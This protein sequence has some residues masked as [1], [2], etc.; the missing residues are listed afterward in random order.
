[1]GHMD[2]RMPV[3]RMIKVVTIAFI[4]GIG[5]MVAM[6]YGA[7]LTGVC[8]WQSDQPKVDNPGYQDNQDQITAI[9]CGMASMLSAGS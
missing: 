5:S 4:F 6:V 3:N 7:I 8:E 1:M 2:T 9:A